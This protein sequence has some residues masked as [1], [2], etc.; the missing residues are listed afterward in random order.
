MELKKFVAKSSTLLN[1]SVE[2]NLAP[3]LEFLRREMGIS[4]DEIRARLITSPNRLS[5]SLENRY[6]P[7]LAACRATAV[8]PLFVL[9]YISRKDEGFCERAGVP[10][11]ALRAAQENV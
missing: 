2:K 1:L 10:L 7:R 6:P 11:E 8:D 5:Y 4:N 3:T 9:K